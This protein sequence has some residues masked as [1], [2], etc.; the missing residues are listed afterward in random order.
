MSALTTRPPQKD[1]KLTRQG[2][3]VLGSLKSH[4]PKQ[5]K[6]R[7]QCEVPG[8]VIITV[9]KQTTINSWQGLHTFWDTNFLDFSG[10]ILIFQGLLNSHQPLHSRDPNFPYCLPYT[11]YFLVEF[12]R[13][14][15]LSRTSGLFPGL[16]SPGKCHNKIPRLSRF[17]RT[18]TN[19]V[20]KHCHF[21]NL[22]NIL[23]FDLHNFKWRKKVIIGVNFLF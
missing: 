10:L 1:V 18:C 11:S 14:P 16:S 5:L 15:E 20:L 22:I 23:Y 17:S 3:V 13:F 7:R 9:T 4:I 12:N 19:P 2:K 6:W 8:K 21:E